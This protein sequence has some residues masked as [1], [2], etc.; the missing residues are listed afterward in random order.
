MYYAKVLFTAMTKP[1]IITL[2]PHIP[3]RENS[4]RAAFAMLLL[5][6]VWDE[7]G[8]AGLLGIRLLD[9]A[10]TGGFP[11]YVQKSLE[12]R[13]AS[14]TLLADTGTPLVNDYTSATVEDFDEYLVEQADELSD[15]PEFMSYGADSATA[16]A[17]PLPQQH[18]EGGTGKS[19]LIHALTKYTQILYGKTVGWFGSVLKTAPTGGAAYNIGGH[20]WHSALG[21]TTFSRLTKKSKLSD[22]QVVSLQKNLQGDF[23]QMK[24]INGTPIVELRHNIA[25]TN[26]EAL[27][28]KQIFEK[29][30]H[31]IKL[32]EN[33]RA[34]SSG[35]ELSPL[36]Q[37]TRLARLGQVRDSNVLEIMNQRVV[38]SMEI[39]MKQADSE[40]VWV[41]STHRRINEINEGFLAEMTKDP[42]TP[43]MRLIAK[44]VPTKA[45]IDPP[46]EATRD[47]LYG[48]GGGAQSKSS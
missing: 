21:K 13:I 37:F 44:H 25:R 46:D 16:D 40:A 3:L 15:R 35:S 45:G 42:R 36:A 10:P 34:Q 20:T 24:P 7:H 41:T 33:V 9:D 48:F 11:K 30:T 14:E 47:I 43:R 19:F 27:E 8:E 22:K 6:G 17:V 2:S 29:M 39:A 28:G 31:F 5:H 26:L 1:A 32:T 18:G 4:E 38:N 23:Y 12:K